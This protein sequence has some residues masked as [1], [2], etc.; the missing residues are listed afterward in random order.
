MLDLSTSINVMPHSVYVSLKLGPLKQTGVIIQLADHSN[1]YPERVVKDVLVKINNLIFPIDF[2]VLYMEDDASLN[3]SPIL[4]GRPFLKT[5]KTKIDVDKGILTMKFDGK[6]TEFDIFKK[7]IK[8]HAL[9]S[10]N[11]ANFVL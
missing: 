5:L 9:S 11:T 1:A 7:P 3:P 8:N 2:Y 4:L 10:I 6:L